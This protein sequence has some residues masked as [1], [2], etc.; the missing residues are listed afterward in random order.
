MVIKHEAIVKEQLTKQAMK[1]ETWAKRRRAWEVEFLIFLFTQHKEH[2]KFPAD[3]DTVENLLEFYA[4]D[5]EERGFGQF[6]SLPLFD[7]EEFQVMDE[8]IEEEETAS[9]NISSGITG[10]MSEKAPDTPTRS[11]FKKLKGSSTISLANAELSTLT[12][13]KKTP[14]KSAKDTP[15]DTKGA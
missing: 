2:I 1:I 6:A 4:D 7:F 12:K 14:A 13:P 8:E 3:D 5:D 11:E 10:R 15:K 9:K